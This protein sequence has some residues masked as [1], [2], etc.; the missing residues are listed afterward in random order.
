M[1]VRKTSRDSKAKTDNDSSL[2]ADVPSDETPVQEKP[3]EHVNTEPESVE[4]SAP[5]ERQLFSALTGKRTNLKFP[6]LL[7][8]RVRRH[9]PILPHRQIF[10][11]SQLPLLRIIKSMRGNTGMQ[12]KLGITS[13]VPKR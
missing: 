8:S 7:K 9:H 11:K 1:P 2:P 6:N 3:K 13:Q 10:P 5:E 4:K 12:I